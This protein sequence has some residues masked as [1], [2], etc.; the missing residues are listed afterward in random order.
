MVEFT[1]KEKEKVFDLY[2]NRMYDYEKLENYFNG[3]FRYSQFK[4]LIWSFYK[5]YGGHC[6]VKDKGERN[7]RK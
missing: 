4:T 3:K 5:D 7:G 1:E 2:F 6:F